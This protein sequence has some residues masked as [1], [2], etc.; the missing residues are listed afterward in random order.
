MSTDD[1]GL[2]GQRLTWLMILKFYSYSS[3]EFRNFL[4]TDRFKV[5]KSTEK[6]QP[7][8]QRRL[9]LELPK[10]MLNEIWQFFFILSNKASKIQKCY[11]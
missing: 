1:N 8:I 4:A 6:P 2:E 7:K 5:L 11:F 3:W 10:R 9:T